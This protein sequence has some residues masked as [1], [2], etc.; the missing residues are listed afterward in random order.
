MCMSME[1]TEYRTVI[2]FFGKFISNRNSH[3]DGKRIKKTALPFPTVHRLVLQFKCVRI[4][5]K[6]PL[7]EDQKNS[8]PEIIEQV[9]NIVCE[10]P[11]LTNKKQEIADNIRISE[12][13]ELH[14][15]HEELRMKNLFG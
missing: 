1:T 14:I 4:S 2:L 6:E 12:E 8:T 5:I 11:S 3:K 9:L 10:D 7:D 13:L 15:L